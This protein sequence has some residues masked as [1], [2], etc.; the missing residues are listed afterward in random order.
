MG[1]YTP[2]D[3]EARRRKQDRLAALTIEHERFLS[4]RE[5]Q[6]RGVRDRKGNLYVLTEEDIEKEKSGRKEMAQLNRELY[7]GGRPS[8][9]ATDPEWDDVVPIPAVEPENAL[10]AI[11]YPDDYAE[12]R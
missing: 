12:G 3:F 7:D 9:Y 10:A 8:R 6:E 5:L 2:E 4:R 11:A 1:E